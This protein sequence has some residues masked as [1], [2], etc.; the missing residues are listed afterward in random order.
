MTATDAFI[1]GYPGCQHS[2]KRLHVHLRDVDA[3]VLANKRPGVAERDEALERVDRA[4]TEMERAA[5]D[6][7]LR[8]VIHLGRPFTTDD[9]WASLKRTW[10]DFSVREPRLMGVAIRAAAKAGS[11]RRTNETR[12]S[13]RPE[14]HRRPCRVWWPS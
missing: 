1:C 4:S 14:S 8:F 11:I 5:I 13:N 7:A 10:P 9:V 3:A 12:D 6:H 2:G